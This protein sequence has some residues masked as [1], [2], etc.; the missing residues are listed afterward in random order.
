MRHS[1]TLAYDSSKIESC[2]LTFELTGVQKGCEAPL[3]HVRVERFVGRIHALDA[4]SLNQ[5]SVMLPEY[6]KAACLAPHCRMPHMR[7][8]H[9]NN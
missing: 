2:H 5:P 7:S 9:R 6:G 4:A 1:K 8:V 3:L